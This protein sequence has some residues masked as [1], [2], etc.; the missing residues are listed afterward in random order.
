VAVSHEF[1]IC[2]SL[3]VQHALC[4]TTCKRAS[5]NSLTNRTTQILLFP[6]SYLLLDFF[7]A[8]ASSSQTLLFSILGELYF[9]KL[10]LDYASTMR[11]LSVIVGWAYA[12]SFDFPCSSCALPFGVETVICSSGMF[13]FT[14]VDGLPRRAIGGAGH[15]GKP[16]WMLALGVMGK[17][18]DILLLDAK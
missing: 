12:H 13:K 10:V 15:V 18:L 9:L 4:S 3:P 1:I 2:Y 6:S 17:W 16:R 8:S 14:L 11:D 5:P 7:T